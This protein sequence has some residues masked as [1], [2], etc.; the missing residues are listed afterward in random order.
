MKKLEFN[1]FE[2][3]NDAIEMLEKVQAEFG[4]CG[5]CE[6]GTDE[7]WAVSRCNGFETIDITYDD[8]NDI[9]FL[10]ATNIFDGEGEEIMAFVKANRTDIR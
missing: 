4:G 3:R 10:D 1:E 8:E 5:I 9:Y 7:L 6:E 2:L